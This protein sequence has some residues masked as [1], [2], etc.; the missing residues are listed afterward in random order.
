[1]KIWLYNCWAANNLVYTKIE[2]E[3]E[4]HGLTVCKYLEPFGLR[5]DIPITVQFKCCSSVRFN[6]CLNFLKQ[7]EW[8]QLLHGA[9]LHLS[10][11]D[12]EYC[13][14][15]KSFVK[16]AHV[17]LWIK[18]MDE[19]MQVLHGTKTWNLIL[20]HHI[21][22]LLVVNVSTKQSATLNSLSNNWQQFSSVQERLN[23]T[24]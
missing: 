5:L 1:M 19:N 2:I 12:S 24:I 23:Q 15:P 20:L 6:L 8:I 16:V 18:V 9:T 22:M 14:K 11:E 7:F 10:D 4:N 13:S 17:P 3:L 21:G